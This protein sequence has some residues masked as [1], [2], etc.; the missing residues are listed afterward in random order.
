M[1]ILGSKG[2][3]AG[4][5]MLNFN[6]EVTNARGCRVDMSLPFYDEKS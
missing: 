1:T 4:S 3:N 5:I 6:V 2:G